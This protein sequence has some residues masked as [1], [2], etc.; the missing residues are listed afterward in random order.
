[1]TSRFNQLPTLKINSG[2]RIPFTYKGKKYYGVQ[3]DTVA[4]ALYANGVRIYARSLKY[5]RPRGFYSMD[6]ECSNTMMEVDGIPNVRTETTQL[7][8]NMEIKEQNVKGSAENDMMGFM[9]KMDWAMPA[10]FYYDVMHKPAK[11]WP[12][13]Q[14]QIRKA[15]GIGVLSPEFIMPGKFDEIFPTCD[16]CVIGGGPAGMVA[17]LA[18]AET[19]GRVILMEA[20]PWL[21]GNFDYRSA[22]YLDGQTYHE[23]AEQ[24]AAEV[25]IAKNIRVFTHTANVGVYN[26]NLVTGFQV[27]KE[28][29]AFDERYVEIRATSVVVATGCI[30]RPLL[31]DNNE[32]PGVMQAGT[33]LRM[34]NTYGLLPG[35]TAVFSIGHDLGLEAAIALFDLGMN[36]PVI[37]DIR[38]DGQDP[39]LLKA[40][41][42]RKITILKGW[43]ATEA[44]GRKEVKSV[45]IKSVDATVEK[46]F[47]C[48]LLVASAGFTP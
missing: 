10:G 16:T 22:A 13:A 19:G 24:L 43:V 46:N 34:A 44:Q 29:D 15:A 1:M 37:A 23:R 41:L 21:G 47:D 11:I 38:E 20:R 30:E 42:D 36:I 18:A 35:K 17:A 31:F 25:E 39:V 40:V 12:I 27:G 3:G 45:T 32:R 9:D 14:K 8:P 2:E 28:G 5:H 26:N 33:A 7:K 4:T 6:G 48:D